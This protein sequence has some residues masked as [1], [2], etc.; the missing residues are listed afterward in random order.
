[1]KQRIIL[2]SNR[3]IPILLFLWR[4]KIAT[5]KALHFRFFS[6]F[7]LKTAYHRLYLL[8]RG[9]FIQIRASLSGQNP[10]WCLT[11]KALW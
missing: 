11:K 9:G 7:S 6:K 5:T 3:D 4:W 8:R 2:T 10:V 1:M